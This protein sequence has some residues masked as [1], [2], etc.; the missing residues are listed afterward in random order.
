QRL[1]ERSIAP[2][3]AE[4]DRT[5]V[6]LPTLVDVL[7]ENGPPAVKVDLTIL[8]E[9]YRDIEYGK[10]LTDAKRTLNHV[11][12]VQPFKGRQSD[13]NVRCIFIESTE[14]GATDRFRG[15]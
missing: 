12:A 8:A 4:I 9:G 1:W 14:T 2:E 11:F 7:V 5:P 3:L 10:F 6:K 15:V 13:F